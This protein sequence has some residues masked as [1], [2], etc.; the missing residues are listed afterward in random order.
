MPINFHPTTEKAACRLCTSQN[1]IRL[2]DLGLT[3]AANAFRMK[4]DGSPINVYDLK[5]LGCIR[6]GHVQLSHVVSPELLFTNYKYASGTSA[7]FIRHFESYA[8]AIHERLQ[9]VGGNRI[10]E[11]GSNDG[12]LMSA[13]RAFDPKLDVVGIEPSPE[14]DAHDNKV[15]G[16]FFSEISL[17]FA[18]AALDGSFQK[19]DLAVANNV[20]AHI[21]NLDEVFMRL[22][23]HGVKTVVFEVQAEAAIASA[24][25]SALFSPKDMFD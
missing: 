15:V 4:N 19:F 5:V 8:R 24:A 25:L 21:D 16:G 7:T 13:L 10:L 3:P 18:E 20:F 17:G 2:W 9:D 12:T 23:Q 11:I 1:L 22:Y 6:C 14:L